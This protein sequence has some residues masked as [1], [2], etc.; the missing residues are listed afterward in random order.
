MLKR[1]EVVPSVFGKAW[2]LTWRLNRQE[3]WLTPPF[4]TD[5]GQETTA[6][7]QQP[8]ERETPCS[9]CLI[10]LAFESKSGTTWQIN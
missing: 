7:I 2:K 10:S 6:P 4:S 1:S 5:S 3:I 9:L 8:P